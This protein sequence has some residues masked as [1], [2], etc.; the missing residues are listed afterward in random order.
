MEKNKPL[1]SM[2]ERNLL[3]FS[4]QISGD[5]KYTWL[6]EILNS[7]N[8]LPFNSVDRGI[9][10]GEQE[11]L[12][13]QNKLSWLSISNQEWSR[14][15]EKPLVTHEN[16]AK[17]MLC[18][19]PHNDSYY[20]INNYNGKEIFVG[21]TCNSYVGT[22]GYKEFK[23][24][25]MSLKQQ[26]RLEKLEE[27]IPN[28]QKTIRTWV[29]R[30]DE[31]V[32]V[33]PSEWEK[34]YL[35][36]GKEIE[37]TLQKAIK[38]DKNANYLEK[39]KALLAQ[40]KQELE[41]ILLRC[42]DSL[43]F[44]SFIIDK[45]IQKELLHKQSEHAKKIIESVKNSSNGEVPDNEKPN[46]Q[47]VE[48]LQKYMV[49]FN[50]KYNKH[51]CE[52]SKVSFGK[53][54]IDVYFNSRNYIFTVPSPSFFKIFSD[55][56]YTQNDCFKDRFINLANKVRYED[57]AE[58]IYDIIKNILE[59]SETLSSYDPTKDRKLNADLYQKERE[60]E[61]SYREDINGLNQRE[62]EEEL[63]NIE[64]AKISI[65]PRTKEL[66]NDKY[67]DIQILT[68]DTIVRLPKN[69]MFNLGLYL[70]FH[71][72][73]E[74]NKRYIFSKITTLKHHDRSQLRNAYKID[75]LAEQRVLN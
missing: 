43:K 9:V 58:Y 75:I 62:Y 21:S 57:R 49:L 11:E 16:K 31:A 64:E 33:V 23:K 22:E 61:S 32:I 26:L 50:S 30:L 60:I 55:I 4:N 38:T 48:F 2:E 71:G 73:T 53:V 66:L 51:N 12:I 59:N 69:D 56:F 67:F 3:L 20:F 34:H 40:G 46:I 35:S 45:N 39:L 15:N 1:I 28:I 70:I 14:R 6:K 72:N 54:T 36:I 47:L 68:S 27:T 8:L 13:N 65:S 25:A 63:A 5:P 29:D 10:S 44:N 18:G 41:D 24:L 42:Q 19:K 52:I 37:L 7:N 17:C 74:K